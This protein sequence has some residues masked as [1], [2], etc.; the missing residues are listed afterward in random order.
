MDYCDKVAQ[1]FETIDDSDFANIDFARLA[2]AAL[3]Q[4]GLSLDQQD[5]IRN[6]IAENFGVEDL[7]FLVDDGEDEVGEE[8]IEGTGTED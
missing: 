2:L 5:R 1:V 8:V 7:E 3:D 6:V 4:A